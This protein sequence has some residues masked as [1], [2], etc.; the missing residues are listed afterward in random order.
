MANKIAQREHIK[1]ALLNGLVFEK[2]MKLLEAQKKDQGLLVPVHQLGVEAHYQ[3][4]I[5]NVKRTNA[6]LFRQDGLIDKRRRKRFGLKG[7]SYLV[8][9]NF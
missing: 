9:A 4:M 3:L 7:K 8:K 2:T 1:N 5:A 6:K